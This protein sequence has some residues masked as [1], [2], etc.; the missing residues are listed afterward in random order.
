MDGPRG[1]ELNL[2]GVFKTNSAGRNPGNPNCFLFPLTNGGWR[3][4]RFSP[5]VA[6]AEPGARTARG[7]RRVTSTAGRTWP[8]PPRPTAASKTRTKAATSSRRRKMPCRSPRSWARTTSRSTRCSRA[9]R[10]PS[11]PH[12]DGRLVMEIE[13]KKG[14]AELN[15]ARRLARQEDQVGP[16][17]RDHHQRQE[18]RRRSGLTRVRQPPSRHQDPGQAICR[19]GGPRR[20]ANGSDNPAA[21]VK[22]L[23]QN[24]GNAKDAAECIM[25]GA[26]GKGWRLVSLPFREEYPGGR[27]WNLDAAQFRYPAGGPGA[28]P[29]AA[30]IRTG[31]WCSTTS[32]SN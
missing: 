8:S 23:L 29:D 1:K 19:L 20:A 14:D 31:T 18:R 22:M 30:C 16:R 26:V 11:R 5:G 17:L 28:G 21:N 6:E 9:A 12:K 32:A 25:G 13:R 3:V 4:Y 2:V 24:L 7:G 15:G 27:Q 10:P